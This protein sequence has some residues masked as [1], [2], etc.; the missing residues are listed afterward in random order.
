MID[1]DIGKTLGAL[2]RTLPFVVLRMVVYAAIALS[3]V[4]VSAA[5]A[6]IGAAFAALLGSA[7]AGALWGGM[8]GFGIVSAVLFW[9]RE[10]LLYLVKG[11][12][13]AVLVE[14]L[15][16]RQLPQGL[17][18]IEHGRKIIQERFV[19]TS[20][21][22]GVDMLIKGVLRVINRML[23]SFASFVPVPGLR[24]VMGL[25]NRVVNLSLTYTDEVILAH[26]ILM[27]SSNPWESSKDALILYAQNYSAIL[28]N[29]VFLLLLMWG[30][31][32]LVF[33]VFLAPAGVIAAMLPGS[34]GVVGLLVALACAW[35]V[36]AALL[37]PF[38]VAAMMQVF[39]A[40]TA[41]QRPDPTWDAR[42]SQASGQFKQLKAN[43]AAGSPRPAAGVI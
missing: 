2:A 27:G 40:V 5:G 22:F 3:Y 42:L 26:N 28:R 43:A 30:L 15:E 32:F 34:V 4:I 7:A 25:A 20:V 41:N 33:V 35:A 36:K 14:V 37:E 1:F 24:T 13:I 8:L 17:G 9:A 23:L 39:F 29:A 31:T 16:G 19:E 6:G 18:Q 11:A 12:H 38:A 10:Y 21:L